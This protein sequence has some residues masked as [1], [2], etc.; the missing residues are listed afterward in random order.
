[1]VT[2][3]KPFPLETTFCLYLPPVLRSV[4][5][6]LLMTPTTPLQH[7]SLLPSP[8]TTPSL[9][10]NLI[11]HLEIR[12]GGVMIEQYARMKLKLVNLS[13][14]HYNTRYLS[15]FL[16]LTSVQ[17]SAKVRALQCV[18]SFYLSIFLS[19]GVCLQFVVYFKQVAFFLQ[20]KISIHINCSR[21]SKKKTKTK[22][23][24]LSVCLLLIINNTLQSS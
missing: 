2:P 22:S 4:L 1:M 16:Y 12:H 3:S 7:L 21:Q 6:D 14:E 9:P 10:K 23:R 11:I 5:E 19:F 18:L 20:A 24:D 8:S 15:M 13:T 17:R